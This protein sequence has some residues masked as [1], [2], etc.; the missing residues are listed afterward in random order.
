MSR[1]LTV[2]GG[3]G[4][5]RTSGAERMAW[6]TTSA[7]ARR[8]H[9]VATL[10]DALPPDD[11]RTA[12]CPVFRSVAELLSDRPWPRPDVV[13]AYDVALPRAVAQAHELARGWN[14]SFVLTPASAPEVWPDRDLGAAL[15]REAGVVY[16]LTQAETAALEAMGVSGARVRAL[17][18][19]PDLVGTPDPAAFRAR[20]ELTGDLVL[21]LGRRIASKGYQV[22]L[23]AAPR[24]WQHLPD[25]LFVFAGPVGDA[26]AA[27]AFRGPLDAR[28]VDVGLLSDQEKHDA[29]AACSVLCLPT[30]ADVFPLVFAEAWACGKPVVTGRFPGVGEVVRDGVDGIVADAR[31][32]AVADALLRLLTDGTARRALGT[33]GLRR[34]RAEMSWDQVVRAVERGYPSSVPSP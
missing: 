20:R 13:H 16:T 1:V 22:L 5:G 34:V 32:A 3:S 14:A 8:G 10:T 15:C 24:V 11:L 21:F 2:F 19:A 23:D 6:R 18:Q 28:V 17:P 26:Q 12:H 27:R 9:Q 29:L 4:Q 31:P 7:L 25:T 33:A 30:S